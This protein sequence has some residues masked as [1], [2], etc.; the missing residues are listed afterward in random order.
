MRQF[1]ALGIAPELLG[2]NVAS[3][4]HATPEKLEGYPKGVAQLLVSE[5]GGLF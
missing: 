5:G 2:S 3:V 1:R 4:A